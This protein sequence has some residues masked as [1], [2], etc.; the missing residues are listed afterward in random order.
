MSHYFTLK[1]QDNTSILI[2][3]RK[4]VANFFLRIHFKYN[5]THIDSY[6]NC[7]QNHFLVTKP[8]FST[9]K[10]SPQYFFI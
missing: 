8:N 5:V 10:K 2:E 3:N 4:T 6:S 1:I 7:D 9:V